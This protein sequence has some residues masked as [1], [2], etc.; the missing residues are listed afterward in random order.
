MSRD[1]ICIDSPGLITAQWIPMGKNNMIS[2]NRHLGAH[3][4]YSSPTEFGMRGEVTDVQ[5]GSF[6]MNKP[7]IFLYTVDYDFSNFLK[8][9]VKTSLY[10]EDTIGLKLDKD[11]L[12]YF[13]VKISDKK[14]TYDEVKILLGKLT[15]RFADYLYPLL[16]DV[17]QDTLST[18]YGVEDCLNAHPAISTYSLIITESLGVEFSNTND[19]IEKYPRKIDAI[20][21]WIINH[22]TI[23]RCHIFIGMRATICV[24]TPSKEL[25]ENL[26]I[27]LFTR[28]LFNTSL[29]LF[30]LIWTISK[31]IKII[32]QEISVSNYRKLKEFN[33]EIGKLNIKLSLLSVLDEMLQISI[34]EKQKVRDSS[35]AKK[36]SDNILQIDADFEDEN[37]KAKDRELILEQLKIDLSAIR[38]GIALR[39]DSIMTKNSEFLNIVLLVLTLISVIGVVKLLALNIREW[40]LVVVVMVPFLYFSIRS[41]IYYIRN[42]K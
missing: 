37:S 21:D 11:G 22:A 38:D 10:A 23:D 35:D 8:A 39:M 5:Q 12:T 32:N 30:S 18:L 14:L 19:F 34:N 15:Y 28:S 9:H 1:E 3:K 13:G 16:T 27:L 17:Q 33:S 26:Q 31:Q 41:F 6:K 25:N 24:G 20:T 2:L 42:F 40:G 4:K 29:R 7:G 36:V